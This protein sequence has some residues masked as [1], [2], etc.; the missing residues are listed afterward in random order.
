MNGYGKLRRFTDKRK[1]I[2]EYLPLPLP[3]PRRNPDRDPATD[4][5][6]SQPL[7]MANQA[8]HPPTPLTSFAERSYLRYWVGSFDRLRAGTVI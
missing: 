4:Q 1:I 7:P 6:G 8:H 5:P 3:L 2:V